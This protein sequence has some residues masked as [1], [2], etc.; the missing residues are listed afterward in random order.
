MEN[1]K[2]WWVES[3]A[4]EYGVNY[5]AG[6]IGFTFDDDSVISEGIAYFTRWDRL[7][8]IPV[9]H[10]LIV[11]GEN[12]CI[13]AVAGQGVIQSNLGKYFWDKNSHIF[14]RKPVGINE[15][16]VNEII[17]TAKK[18]IGASYANGLIVNDMVRATFL[19]HLLDKL[20][21][22]EIFDRI[23]MVLDEKGSFICSE[24]AAYCL[25]S[26]KSWIYNNAG[27]LDRPASAITP[28]S[29]FSDS[30]IFE[31]W[32]NLSVSVI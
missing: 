8:D 32:K 3:Q 1:I 2:N 22:D 26:A 18:E 17:W 25:K 31:Q 29:L 24:L 15:N 7:S 10:A 21:H 4:P 9:S 6:Y 16:I 19:G 28:Q 5:N 13:E 27:I 30:I 23:S 12:T 14:F 20:S 11:I